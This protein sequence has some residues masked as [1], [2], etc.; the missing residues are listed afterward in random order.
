MKKI[1]AV[2]LAVVM[3]FSMNVAVFAA[4]S[5]SGTPIEDAGSTGS[6]KT[7]VIDVAFVELAGVGMAATA[8]LAAK[9]SR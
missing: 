8:V 5:P 2:L 1:Y 9:K 7:G 3:M 4:V 6:P